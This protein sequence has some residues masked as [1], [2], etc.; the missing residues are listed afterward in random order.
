MIGGLFF[1]FSW[2]PEVS[3]SSS[4]IQINLASS[5]FWDCTRRIQL[6]REQLF[7]RS[8]LMDRCVLRKDCGAVEVTWKWS[9]LLLEACFLKQICASSW[10]FYCSYSTRVATRCICLL[11]HTSGQQHSACGHQVAPPKDPM[12]PSRPVLK[13]TQVINWI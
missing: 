12:S 9:C 1:S 6:H 3:Y 5:N 10:P 8:A 4:R 13:I 2:H 7:I 11:G